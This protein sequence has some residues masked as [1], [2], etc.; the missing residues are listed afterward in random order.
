MAIPLTIRDCE[1]FV[2]VLY[3]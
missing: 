3:I 1:G 2:A